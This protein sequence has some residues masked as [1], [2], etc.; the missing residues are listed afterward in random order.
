MIIRALTILVI[1]ITDGLLINTVTQNSINLKITVSLDSRSEKT[2]IVKALINRKQTSSWRS[3]R[4]HHKLGGRCNGS[5]IQCH[6]ESL[7]NRPIHEI[8]LSRHDYLIGHNYHRNIFRD[9]I[10]DGHNYSRPWPA[11]NFQ[12]T[13]K[14]RY[15]VCSWFQYSG[16][17]CIDVNKTHLLD[18]GMQ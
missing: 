17:I 6:D 8:P 1:L 16:A 12:K 2:D 10:F 4:P 7:D 5:S 11:W 14:F 9:M 15:V 13:W 18:C 3:W